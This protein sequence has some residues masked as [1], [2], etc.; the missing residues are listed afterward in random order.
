MVAKA[1][2]TWSRVWRE[3][4]ASPGCQGPPKLEKADRERLLGPPERARHGEHL[5]L[6]PRPPELGERTLASLQ[7]PSPEDFVTEAQEA[8]QLPDAT[9][10]QEA[11]P[12]DPPPSL[13]DWLSR[14]LCSTSPCL[15]PRHLPRPRPTAPGHWTPAWGS[16]HLKVPLSAPGRSGRSASDAASRGR[17]QSQT[18]GT[19]SSAG[20]SSVRSLLFCFLLIKFKIFFSFIYLLLES[21]KDRA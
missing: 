4:A 2:R 13:R 19:Q 20:R 18:Q 1:G 17:R 6:D 5:V 21:E 16:L 12:A 11:G 14:R 8:V 10:R 7:A 3:A 9:Q 15:L